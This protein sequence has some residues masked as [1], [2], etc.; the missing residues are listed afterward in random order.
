MMIVPVDKCQMGR[1]V[2]WLRRTAD[3][4]KPCTDDD[5][6]WPTIGIASTVA[7][8]H[9]VNQHSVDTIVEL[10]ASGTKHADLSNNQDHPETIVGPQ[11]QLHADHRERRL[12]SDV[13]A[14]T[15][16]HN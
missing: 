6:A 16:S 1:Q 5:Y 9:P 13:A 7:R 2:S 8:L 14:A 3:T 15:E 10:P 12:V 11:Q 4:S